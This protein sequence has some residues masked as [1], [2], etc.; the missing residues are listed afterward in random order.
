[1][2]ELKIVGNK[3]TCTAAVII[4]DTKI[5]LGLRHYNS[6]N[7]KAISVWTTPGGRCEEGEVLETN[8]RREVLEETGI[9]ELEIT[10]F[11]GK[12]PGAKDGDVL[13]V[14]LCTTNQQPTLT[15]PDKFSE[16]KWCN[17][18]ELPVN[19][20]NPHIAELLKTLGR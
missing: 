2:N 14:F 9:S 7:W 8:L 13:Y 18:T 12:V 16:W 10:K 20:I 1:M 15:E 3:D 5:L 11:L 17:L 6:S 19:F 4:N